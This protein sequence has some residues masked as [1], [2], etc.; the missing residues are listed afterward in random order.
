MSQKSFAKSNSTKVSSA[1]KGGKRL[2]IDDAD[3]KITNWSHTEIDFE[4]DM[5]KN[6]NQFSCFGRYNYGKESSPI[7]NQL[8]F[9]TGPLKLVT[10]GIPPL[11]NFAKTDKDR[12]HIKIPYDKT[13]ESFV[14]LFK[15]FEALDTWA[16]KNKD[17]FFT[18][19]LGKFSKLY[20]YTPIVRKPQEV[21]PIDDDDDTEPTKQTSNSSERPMY[22]KIKISTDWKSGEVDTTVFLREDGVPVKQ[23]VKT[24][25]DIA[26]LV[27]W[28]STIQMICSC[29][30]LWF[31]KSA[32]KTGRRQYGIAFKILQCEVIERSS[33]GPKVKS[34]FTTYAFDDTIIVEEK[35]E[36]KKENKKVAVKDSDDDSD[37]DSDDDKNTKAEQVGK[38]STVEDSDDDK[39]TKAEQVAK[40]TTV[41][42]SD[43]DSDNDT[44][45]NATK[46]VSNKVESEDSDEESEE[47]VKPAPKQQPKKEEKSKPVKAVAKSGK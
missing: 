25:S 27:T 29:T 11:G 21:I 12:S 46:Q 6:G 47:E 42:D 14:N 5:N 37:E 26:S 38:S 28:Q 33:G 8:V 40:P 32:D 44:P 36:T 2:M 16:I 35:S 31:G 4:N 10:Y 17:K 7:Q 24:I 9:K 19:K 23:E 41:E 39:N 15:M 18:G 3:F 13:Q 43:D 22:A 34:D 30:K 1:P 20:D 45:Q